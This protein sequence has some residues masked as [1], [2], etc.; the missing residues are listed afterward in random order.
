MPH[1]LTVSHN[2]DIWITDVALHQVGYSYL[3]PALTLAVAITL[4]LALVDAVTLA[5]TFTP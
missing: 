3:I 5:L 4:A 1:G 2:D